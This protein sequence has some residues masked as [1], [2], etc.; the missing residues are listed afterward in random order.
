MRGGVSD[1][2]RFAVFW[3]V[4]GNAPPQMQRAIQFRSL[5]RNYWAWA[6]VVGIAA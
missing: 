5:D 2:N 3:P 4:A 1:V 6:I